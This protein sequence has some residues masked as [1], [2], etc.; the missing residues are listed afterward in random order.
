MSTGHALAS[1]EQLAY[2]HAR[3]HVALRFGE[4]V[5]LGNVRPSVAWAR[6]LARAGDGYDDKDNNDDDAVSLAVAFFSMCKRVVETIF[7]GLSAWRNCWCVSTT[8][9]LF[10][11]W[12]SL[13]VGEAMR[14]S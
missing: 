4:E 9:Q 14:V 5:A 8:K 10:S 7:Q 3:E 13:H 1:V 6:H 11:E 12:L 2:V